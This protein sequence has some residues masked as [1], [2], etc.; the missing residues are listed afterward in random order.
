ME[1]DLTLMSSWKSKLN[2]LKIKILRIK[3]LKLNMK[4]QIAWPVFE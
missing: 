2:C 3:N 1:I 4:N